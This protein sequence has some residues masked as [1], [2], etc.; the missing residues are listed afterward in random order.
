M[1]LELGNAASG[2]LTALRVVA[3]TSSGAGW[4]R[5]LTPLG[6][7]EELRPFTSSQQPLALLLPPR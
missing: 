4:L 2:C 1:A 3:D 5:W 7:A 6:W